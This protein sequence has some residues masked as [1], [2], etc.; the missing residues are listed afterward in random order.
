MIEDQLLNFCCLN[1]CLSITINAHSVSVRSFRPFPFPR[2]VMASM[3]IHHVTDI[4]T[5]TASYGA[6]ITTRIRS[7]KL[8]TSRRSINSTG[9][10]LYREG[11]LS[12]T[13]TAP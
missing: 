10:W 11:Q 8:R 7:A 2:V 9:E 3:A 4:A 1:R 12:G 5:F 6:A 13:S